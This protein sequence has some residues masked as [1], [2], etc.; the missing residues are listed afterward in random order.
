ML[1][2]PAG[3]VY[4]EPHGESGGFY[5]LR[6][7]LPGRRLQGQ[8]RRTYLLRI[9]ADTPPDLKTREP[10]QFR[11]LLRQDLGAFHQ[12]PETGETRPTSLYSARDAREDCLARL[13]ELAERHPESLPPG[14]TVAG[15][16]EML[17]RAF[18]LLGAIP[19]GHNDSSAA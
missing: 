19:L 14:L 17:E 10:T 5:Y 16:S 18:S 12:D 4:L 8:R 11:S 9:A 13:A 7:Y 15:V 2:I 6:L 1:S 3:R